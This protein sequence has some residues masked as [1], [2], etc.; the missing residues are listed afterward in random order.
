MNFLH[1]NEFNNEF[2]SFYIELPPQ[3]SSSSFTASFFVAIY[4]KYAKTIS[5]KQMRERA[6]QFFM[7]WKRERDTNQLLFSLLEAWHFTQRNVTALGIY[8]FL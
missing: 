7:F 8:C 5:C 3:K 1:I 6:L 2:F 4:T